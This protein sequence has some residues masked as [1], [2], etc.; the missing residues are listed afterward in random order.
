MLLSLGGRARLINDSFWS[1]LNRA[2]IVVLR[3]RW[4]WFASCGDVKYVR[5]V[6]PLRKGKCG[7][8]GW[9]LRWRELVE[10][11]LISRS[12]KERGRYVCLSAS[13]LVRL[14]ARS[15]GGPSVRLP[16]VLFCPFFSVLS[17]FFVLVTS[18]LHAKRDKT[19]LQTS[20]EECIVF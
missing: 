19:L 2:D 7:R 1:L 3:E 5:N 16:A 6:G 15:C 14:S 9:F 12:S 8:S 4:K 10:E 13:L 20:D 17:F 18:S 11:P